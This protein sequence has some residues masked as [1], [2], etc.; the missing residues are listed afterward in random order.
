MS[1]FT[2]RDGQLHADG[3]PL[4]AIAEAVGTPTY[5][6]SAETIRA[7]YRRIASA[8]APLSPLCW[9][10]ELASYWQRGGQTCALTTWPYSVCSP[11]QVLPAQQGLKHSPTKLVSSG[12][13]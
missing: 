6:Y 3:V 9:L 8:F 13:L 2:W 11:L 12:S 4:S 5:V 10:A 1:G 7:A